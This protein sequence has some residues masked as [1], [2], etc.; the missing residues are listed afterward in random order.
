MLGQDSED[1]IWLRFVFE[2]VIWTQPSGPLCLWQCLNKGTFERNVYA[3]NLSFALRP[4]I[5]KQSFWIRFQTHWENA[6]GILRLQTLLSVPDENKSLKGILCR[7]AGSITKQC[8]VWRSFP[9]A[10]K[11][12]SRLGF[13]KKSTDKNE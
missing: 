12:N 6:K 8:I 10:I 2:L 9:A 1:E 7:K 11:G 4:W 5:T 13:G 3:I